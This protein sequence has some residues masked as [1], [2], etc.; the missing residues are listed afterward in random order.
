MAL[1]NLA[2]IRSNTISVDRFIVAMLSLCKEKAVLAAHLAV[3]K[4]RHDNGF[5]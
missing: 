3:A 1:L 5:I 2:V 4:W